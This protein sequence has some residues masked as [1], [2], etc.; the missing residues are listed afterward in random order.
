MKWIW[1][2]AGPGM[3]LSSTMR[4]EALVG[5]GHRQF[6]NLA[7]TLTKLCATSSVLAQERIYSLGQQLHFPRRSPLHV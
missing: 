7:G 5:W 1:N 3:M 2:R 4:G 6:H